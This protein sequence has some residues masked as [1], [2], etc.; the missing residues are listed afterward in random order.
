MRPRL[1]AFSACLLSASAFAQNVIVLDDDGGPGVDYTNLQDAIDAAQPYDRIDARTGSYGYGVI[2]KPLTIMGQPFANHHF[3]PVSRTAQLTI[4]GLQAGETVVVADF[5]ADTILVEP[6]QGAIVLDRIV[7]V[8]IHIDQARDVRIRDASV[9]QWPWSQPSPAIEANDS[10]VQLV[11]SVVQ[12]KDQSSGSQLN[13]TDAIVVQGNS[14]LLLADVQVTG[15]KGSDEP[16][17]AASPG[18]GGNA[19][20]CTN[21]TVRVLRSSLTSGEGGAGCGGTVASDGFAIRNIASSIL[22]SDSTITGVVSNPAL[23]QDIGGFPMMNLTGGS[24]PGETADFEVFVAGGISTRL[25]IGR[26][27]TM[28]PLPLIDL[29]LLHSAE[30]GLS[31]GVSPPSGQRTLPFLIPG[32][33]PGTLVFAQASGTNGAGT[34]L[35]NS[36]TLVVR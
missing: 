27:P 32:L 22:T 6:N 8:D 2:T 9:I 13:G 35:S 20:R 5:E 16:G 29:P 17:C 4:A 21:S 33:Q 36:V 28:T 34:A 24:Q 15:G 10:F 12:G 14:T 1:L 19:L 7:S 3:G 30:R 23:V 26:R 18:F 31:L 25:F 11:G